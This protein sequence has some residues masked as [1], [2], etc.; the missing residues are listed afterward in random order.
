MARGYKDLCE[1]RDEVHATAGKCYGI[2]QQ[3]YGFIKVASASN[4]FASEGMDQSFGDQLHELFS[5]SHP[6]ETR[7][8]WS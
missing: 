6:S 4:S 2:D 1:A 3:G 5:Y 8:V 7:S